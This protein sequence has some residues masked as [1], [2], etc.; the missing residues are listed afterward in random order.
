MF[1]S[2]SPALKFA[3]PT[4]KV[5]DTR[6]KDRQRK[7]A[8]REVS[9]IVKARDKGLCRCC[10]KRGDDAH[11][12]IYRSHGGANHPNNLIWCC[13]KCHQDMHAKLIHVE[14]G[15]KVPAK[16]VKFTRIA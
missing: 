12:L 7:K 14:W 2:N 11:H 3:K 15:G 1:G 8:W 6:E 5:L 16:S 13:R 9:A 10:G 4:A